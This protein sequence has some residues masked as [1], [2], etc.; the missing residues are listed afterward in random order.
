ME[1]FE[2]PKIGFIGLGFVGEAIRNSYNGNFHNICIDTD[3]SKGYVST[4]KEIMDAKGIFICVPSPQ[5]LDGSCNTD[6]L[7]S[8]LSNLKDYKGVIISKVTA[9]PD[10]YQRLQKDYD[11][12]VYVPEFLT[13]AN[14]S[15]DYARASFMIIGGSVEAYRNETA[16]IL[17]LA[18]PELQCYHCSITEA[19]LIKYA[20]NS[21]LATKVVFM[22]EMQQVANASNCDWENVRRLLTLDT[23]I[24]ASHM[25]VPGMDGHYGF[26]GMCFPKDT[27]ALIEYAKSVG[28][29]LNVLKEAV[30]KNTLLRLQKPK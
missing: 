23:R 11:N 10:V 17:K 25:Q 20:I 21:F 13:A 24:G 6:I 8:V 5:R 18:K 29:G 26:G 16:R 1:L 3:V 28:V 22:N 12:L 30:K 2:L 4:Y 15:L 14:A 27:S 9:T 7:E 19:S